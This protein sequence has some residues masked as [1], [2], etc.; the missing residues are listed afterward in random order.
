MSGWGLQLGEAGEERWVSGYFPAETGDRGK[1]S[2]P[3][4]SVW[5]GLSYILEECG[6]GGPS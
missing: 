1:K 4:L 6:W 3:F 2:S 5:R